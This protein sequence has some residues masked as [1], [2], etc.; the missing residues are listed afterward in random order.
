MYSK[1]N[2]ILG[3]ISRNPIEAVVGFIVWAFRKLK[4]PRCA[5]AATRFMAFASN[6]RFPFPRNGTKQSDGKKVATRSP[7]VLVT[8]ISSASMSSS[9]PQNRSWVRTSAP[10]VPGISGRP[11]AW[12]GGQSSL[13][14]CHSSLWRCL[15]KYSSER[16]EFFQK[17]SN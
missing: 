7:W 11:D 2:K 12:P 9:S 5:P 3:K 8:S 17:D 14:P 6:F 13:A 10:A 1:W 16:F 4:N 15:L